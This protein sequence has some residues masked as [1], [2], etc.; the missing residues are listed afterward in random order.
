[1]CEG[2]EGMGGGVWRD[3]EGYQHLGTGW[4]GGV[5]TPRYRLVCHWFN[6]P[7]GVCM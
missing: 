6:A 3:M 5:P 2:G 4:Y 1:M 7:G